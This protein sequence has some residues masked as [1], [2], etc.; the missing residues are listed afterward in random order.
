MRAKLLCGETKRTERVEIR[1][2]KVSLYQL[3]SKCEQDVRLPHA[4]L[5]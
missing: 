4:F 2:V 5:C 3:L 1:S